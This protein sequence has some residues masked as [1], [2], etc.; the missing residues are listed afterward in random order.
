[1]PCNTAALAVAAATAAQGRSSRQ[2]LLASGEQEARDRCHTAGSGAVCTARRRWA[3][4]NAGRR[5]A[6]CAIAAARRITPVTSKFCSSEH[7][8][9]REGVPFEACFRSLGA[10]INIAR[11]KFP[12]EEKGGVALGS[13]CAR[14]HASWHGQIGRRAQ[15]KV[16]NGAVAAAWVSPAGG[17]ACM[18]ACMH[19]GRAKFCQVCMLSNEG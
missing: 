4:G 2:L 17:H 8:G 12:S 16:R 15:R 18:H 6:A 3:H 14:M 9:R 19:V 1:M 13:E 11:P 5:F 7:G 10:R